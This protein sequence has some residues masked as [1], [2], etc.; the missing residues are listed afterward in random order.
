[1]RKV[2]EYFDSDWV[3]YWELNALPVYDDRYINKTKIKIYS[4]KGYINLCG[5]NVPEDD[6]ECK[7]FIVISIVSL[8]V[9][10]NKYYLQVCL[11]NCTYK[12]INKQVTDNLY[13]NV[14]ED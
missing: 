6:I 11:D 2:L 7:Y 3:W 1:M 4:N 8:L 9:Y 14:F 10:N 5:L 12:I 13:Q